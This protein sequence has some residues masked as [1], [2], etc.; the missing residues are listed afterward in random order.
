MKILPDFYD[1][2]QLLIFIP[3]PVQMRSYKFELFTTAI[4]KN[5]QLGI[6]QPGH[7]LPSI[8]ELK[9]QYQTSIST[10]QNGYEHL[11]IL[12]LVVSVPKSGYYVATHLPQK[13]NESMQTNPVVR[14]AVFEK[15][16]ELITS[17]GTKKKLIEFNVAMAGDLI[18]SQKLLLRTMQ[19]MIRT[20]GVSLL[21]YYPPGG[22]EALKSNIAKHAIQYGLR[23][24]P[25]EL[26][27]TDGAL[28]ALF[29]ALS[30]VCKAGDVIAVESPCVF[31]ILEVISVLQLKVVEVPV[32]SS[33][34]FDTDFFRRACRKGR[35]KAL[36]ITPNFHN[37]TGLLLS[38]EIKKTLVDISQ[39]HDIAVIENDIYGDLN[40]NGNRPSTLKNFDESG[41][42]MTFTSYS[43][44][45]AP[46][47]RLGWLSAGKFFQRAE[48]VRFSLGSTASPIYQE[49]VN[50]LL[51]STS[52]DRHI[53][54]FRMLLAKN[55]YFTI[56]LLSRYFPQ[57]MF[58]IPPSGGY[59][60]WARMPNR[61]D[62]DD[63]YRKC[64]SIG[65]RFTPGSTFAFSAKFPN[66]FRVVFADK[67]SPPKIRALERI[68]KLMSR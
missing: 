62:M 32:D 59:N 64:Q 46:G 56:N 18:I 7:K 37:P 22:S 35:I 15:K 44:T 50:H 30:S 67:Y 40:F 42:V 6:Y 34:G 36:V 49:T 24:N 19:Q 39:Q 14:D 27:I 28:Q 5:I 12:G 9:K 63:F 2:I 52:Y 57:D 20:Q 61:T 55:A 11:I 10:I 33:I 38:D 26:L 21:R 47:I 4:E 29:I 31:S 3:Q 53:R 60:L 45:L 51:S 68:G 16:I 66:H 41:L 54:S 48:Q 13:P 17:S 58:I 8:R 25:R 1:F 23:I 43:K 65:V